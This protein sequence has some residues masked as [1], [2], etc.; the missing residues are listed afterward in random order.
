MTETTDVDPTDVRDESAAERLDRNWNDT[1]QELCVTQTGTQ[2]ITGFLL[3][4]AFQNRF[5]DLDRDQIII[6]LVLVVLAAVSSIL[7]L[8]PRSLHRA[9][10]VRKPR[11][12]WSPQPTDSSS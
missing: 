11:L 2:I 4:L 9:C 5:T 10:F 7:G 3:T 1:L 8:A 6:Y 12:N